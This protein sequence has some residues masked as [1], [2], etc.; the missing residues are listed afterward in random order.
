[1]PSS[2]TG[3]VG[4]EG[5]CTCETWECGLTE[6]CDAHEVLVV[7]KSQRNLIEKIQCLF[8]LDALLSPI[9]CILFFLS[10]VFLLSLCLLLIFSSL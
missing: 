9:C 10:A 3:R 2:G 1:M 5:G 6:I 4:Q 8:L 7:A